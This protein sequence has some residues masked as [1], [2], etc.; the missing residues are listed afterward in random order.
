MARLN[1]PFA[2]ADLQ[3]YSRTGPNT[4][5]SRLSNDGEQEFQCGGQ[6]ST[7]GHLRWNIL[8]ISRGSRP[9]QP[10]GFHFQ[11]EGPAASSDCSCSGAHTWSSPT[12]EK[13]WVVRNLAATGPLREKSAPRSQFVFYWNRIPSIFHFFVWIK[14]KRKD[15]RSQR[16]VIHPPLTP[17]CI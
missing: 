17:A 1:E 13:F 2:G 7:F 12:S 5:V 16:L 8:D 14:K 4:E 15:S 3:V 6:E 11:M 10:V 9:P